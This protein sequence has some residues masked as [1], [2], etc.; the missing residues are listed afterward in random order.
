LQD[1][2]DIDFILTLPNADVVA[3]A[4]K[5]P[6]TPT[7]QLDRGKLT[8]CPSRTSFG[9]RV[10]LCKS[11]ALEMKVPQDASPKKKNLMMSHFFP[12]PDETDG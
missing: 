1:V 9:L 3:T 10:Y 6:S 5:F 4:M 8:I 11:L 7:K 12:A 2:V